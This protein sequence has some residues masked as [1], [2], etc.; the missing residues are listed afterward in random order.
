M[1]HCFASAWKIFTHSFISHHFFSILLYVYFLLAAC[2]EIWICGT[3]GD[4]FYFIRV[5]KLFIFISWLIY[6][7]FVFATYFMLYIFMLL[8][9]FFVF[10][11][12]QYGI[13]F[14]CFCILQWSGNMSY[15]KLCCW[16]PLSNK[17]IQICALK[18][19]YCGSKE[20]A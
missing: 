17:N 10:Y 15:F 7:F 19:F 2:G 18:S 11:L 3:N 8:C 6:F 5:V 9:F 16:L 20:N 13:C 4:Y 1:L 14:I 12:K